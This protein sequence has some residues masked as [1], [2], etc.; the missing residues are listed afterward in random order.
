MKEHRVKELAFPCLVGVNG[1]TRRELEKKPKV[2]IQEEKGGY[3]LLTLYSMRA[4]KY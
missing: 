1:V 4:L 2:E 3:W